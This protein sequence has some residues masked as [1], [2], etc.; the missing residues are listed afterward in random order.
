M[1]E[2]VRAMKNDRTGFWK[3]ICADPDDDAPRLVFADWLDDNGQPERA[4]VIRV[5]CALAREDALDNKAHVE[6]GVRERV[7]LHKHRAA[8]VEDL[9]KWIRRDRVTFHRGFP[10]GIE[11]PVNQYVCHS[12]GL[13]RKSVIQRLFLDC[14]VRSPH[15]SG[16]LTSV[17]LPRV[18]RYIDNSTQSRALSALLPAMPGMR[19]LTLYFPCRFEENPQDKLAHLLHL[20]VMKSLRR[21]RLSVVSTFQAE[22]QQAMVRQVAFLDLP[23]LTCLNLIAGP[24]ETKVLREVLASSFVGRLTELG[25][26]TPLAEEGGTLLGETANLANL[27]RLRIRLAENRADV[28]RRVVNS[29]HLAGVS[30]LWID[31]FDDSCV[32][33]LLDSAWASRLRA[34][35]LASGLIVSGGL[36]RDRSLLTEKGLGRLVGS[37]CLARVEYLGLSS[38]GDGNVDARVL[39]EKGALP[40]LR[41]L[42]IIARSFGE[43]GVEILASSQ[44]LQALQVVTAPAYFL[45][46]VKDREGRRFAVVAS[47]WL[48]WH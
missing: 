4:E 37:G 13:A 25:I 3:S 5:Q 26:S 29:P 7:L 10:C 31:G 39:A 1:W 19:D 14:T 17:H 41:R 11:C 21:L 15:E 9:P 38:V 42:D 2:D 24:L 8:W 16:L 44:R 20:P 18:R 22:E 33:P 35:K 30:D 23:A 48:D 27:R 46:K 12:A 34:L 47:D 6:L 28:L 45:E 36:E 40:N 32:N 43:V